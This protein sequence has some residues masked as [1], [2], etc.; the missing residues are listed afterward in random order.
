VHVVGLNNRA[1]I[2]AVMAANPDTAFTAMRQPL[3]RAMA[4]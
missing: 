4:A 1:A 2:K 3:L